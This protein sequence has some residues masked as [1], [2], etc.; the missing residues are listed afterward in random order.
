MRIIS[1]NAK[2]SDLFNAS[3]TDNGHHVGDYDGY[4]PDFMPGQHYGD[5]VELKIDVDTGKI[6]NWK[7]P[8]TKQLKDTF[9]KEA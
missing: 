5:Y 4:V 8:T 1:I 3:L 7:K 9:N 6:L 2:C